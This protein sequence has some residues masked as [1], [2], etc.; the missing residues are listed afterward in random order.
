MASYATAEQLR[1][2]PGVTGTGDDT[3][4]DLMLSA[5]SLAID[6]FCG[7]PEDG[8]LAAGTA[9]MRIFPGSDEPWLMLPEN[10]ETT[11]VEVKFSASD[12]TWEEL[13]T[14]LWLPFHGAPDWP[15][16]NRFPLNGIVLLRGGPLTRFLRETQH[17][18]WESEEEIGIPSP[19]PTVR[20]TAKWGYAT[21]TPDLIIQATITQAARWFKRGQSFWADTT[22]SDTMGTLQY[23]KS[24]DP[25]I[26]MMLEL[27]RFVRPIYG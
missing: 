14:S 9:T 24:L 2:Q 5:A 11:K 13:S 22:S 12:T 18:T 17:S 4:I 26:Q 10:V 16:Y 7:R 20:V 19:L 23:R 27:S 21:V 1:A 6:G 25:D 3:T 15:N 8:F